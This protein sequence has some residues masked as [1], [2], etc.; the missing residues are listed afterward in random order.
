MAP[1]TDYLIIGAGA[2]GLAFADTLLAEDPG[3]HITIADRHAKPGGH[4][5]DAYSFVA[6]HQP[7]ATYG[8]NSLPL[9]Q[10]R[11]DAAGPNEGFYELASGAEVSAYFETV[12]RD[13]LL[14][15]GRVRYFPHSEWLGESRFRNLFS[16]EEMQ[17]T[18]R[19]R[20]VDAT[21]FQTSVPS[22]HKRQ[23]TVAEGV[24]VVPP[25]ALPQLWQRGTALPDHYVLLGAGK[26][27][28]DAAIWLLEA[29]IA[30]DRI[31]WVKPRE[32]W[33]L[34]RRYTQPGP[35]FFEDVI[36]GQRALYDAI[37]ASGSVRELFHRLEAA[38]F[39]LRIDQT[40]EPAM[41]HYATI[42]EGEVARLR[43]ITGVMRLGRVA[44]IES[45][46]LVCAAGEAQVPPGSLFID[47]TAS[48]VRPRPVHP[49]WQ[50]GQ[51]TLQLLH[52]PL[53]TLNA[54]VSA[55]IEANFATDEEKNALARPVSWVDEIDGYI[56][57]VAGTGMNRMAWAQ[58]P[59]VAA[60][61]ASSRLDPAARTIAW[62]KEH[63][64]AKLACLAPM[65]QA[66]MAAM[67]NLQR[68]AGEARARRG[69]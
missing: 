4:W 66:M 59:K 63:D 5:N 68:L 29:G 67:P 33:L 28:M 57:T 42:S 15:T 11:I 50:D 32:S 31:S 27:A 18:V 25:G 54:S 43:A 62:L 19:R 40:I 53:V 52:V 48:A 37:A 45:G 14:P 6:L 13:H 47:C 9:G 17:V 69:A 34:N 49:Q 65:Q 44:R 2:V 10:D 21:Y 30:P 39:M 60:F 7:S 1:E 64:P 58:N 22:T 61:L 16:G 36:G 51:I 55:F 3:C 12:M 56:L 24:E 41:F 35:E 26:T 20:L 23:F 38:Q 46:R 8:V